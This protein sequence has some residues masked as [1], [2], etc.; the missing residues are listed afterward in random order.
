MNTTIQVYVSNNHVVSEESVFALQEA[1]LTPGHH[2]LMVHNNQ[3]ID[4]LY[5]VFLPLL[6]RHHTVGVLTLS[7]AQLHDSLLP[8]YTMMVQRGLGQESLQDILA[9]L[10][11]EHLW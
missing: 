2:E 7:R 8:L 4:A 5:E 3:A 1:V 10:Y 6:A 11:L 9:E